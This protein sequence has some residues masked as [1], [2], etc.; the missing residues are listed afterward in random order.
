ME[1]SPISFRLDLME[2]SGTE[3]LGDIELNTDMPAVQK[4]LDKILVYQL[5]LSFH[6]EDL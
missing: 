3:L 6:K 1:K 5:S 2:D 4:K